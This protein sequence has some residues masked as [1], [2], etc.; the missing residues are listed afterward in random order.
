MYHLTVNR[1]LVV[2]WCLFFQLL[3]CIVIFASGGKQY[4]KLMAAVSRDL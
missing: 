4:S 3:V 1:L 2:R